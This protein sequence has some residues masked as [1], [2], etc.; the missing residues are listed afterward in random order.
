MFKFDIP[1]FESVPRLNV[2]LRSIKGEGDSRILFVSDYVPFSDYSETNDNDATLLGAEEGQVFKNVLEFVTRKK[3]DGSQYD[4]RE[5]TVFNWSNAPNNLKGLMVEK[6]FTKTQ[7]QNY[8]ERYNNARLLAF[9]RKMKPDTVIIS[10]MD[11]FKSFMLQYQ[12]DHYPVANDNFDFKNKFGRLLKFKHPDIKPFNIMGTVD[13]RR[14]ATQKQKEIKKYTNL[15][16]FLVEAFELALHGRN[17]HTIDLTDSK[18]YYVDTYKKFCAFYKRLMRAKRVSIDSEGASLARIANK[19]FSIQFALNK[20]DAYFVPLDH[21]DSPFTANELIRIKKALK[22]YF[23]Y[24]KS[25]WHIYQF[26]RHDVEQFI[27]Q[28]GVRY[29]NHRIYDCMAGEF[30]LDENRKLLQKKGGTNS[31]DKPYALQALAEK[32]GSDIY[33][34]IPFSKGDREGMENVKFTSKVIKYGCYDVLVPWQIMECQIA[35]AARVGNENFMQF[36]LGQLSDTV[37]AVAQMEHTG[38]PLDKKYLFSLKSVDSDLDKQIKE[39][40]DKMW[41]LPSVKKTNRFLINA[42]NIPQGFTEP[43]VFKPT[44]EASKQTLFFKVLKLAP[45]K[46]NQKGGGAVDKA[47]KSFYRERVP[48]VKLLD[49]YEQLTKLKS[50]YVDAFYKKLTKDPDCIDGFIR[51]NYDYTDVTTGRLSSS[52]PNLQ[53][54]VNRGI[55]AKTIKRCFIALAGWILCKNDYSAHEVRIWAILGKDKRLSE[56]FRKGLRLRQALR[57]L[58]AKCPAE[59]D[60]FRALQKKAGWKGIKEYDQKL[61]LVARIEDETVKKIASL[62]LEIEQFGD[63]HRINYNHFYGTPILKITPDQ[64]Q[65]IKAVVFGV[66]YGKCLVYSSLVP[67]SDGLLTLGELR[68]ISL[69]G[70]KERGGFLSLRTKVATHEGMATTNASFARKGKTQLVCTLDGDKIEGLKEHKIWILRD[71]ALQFVRLDKLKEGDYLPKSVGTRLFSATVPVLDLNGST[72]RMNER[73][74]TLLGLFVAE[75]CRSGSFSNADDRILNWFSTAANRLLNDPAKICVDSKT[76]CI[77]LN[78][79]SKNFLLTHTGNGLSAD[80]FVP[81]VIRQSPKKYQQAFLQG[82]WEGDGSI[83]K[84]QGFYLCEYTTISETL[85]YQV[86]AM[87]ENMGVLCSITEFE[88]WATNGTAKQVKR[89]GYKLR[90][91]SVALAEFEAQAG[92][93][94]DGKKAALLRQAVEHMKTGKFDKLGRANAIPATHIMKRIYARLDE[95]CNATTYSYDMRNRWGSITTASKTYKLGAITGSTH[96]QNRIRFDNGLVTRRSIDSLKKK[97]ASC[98]DTLRRV[99]RNDKEM[100]NLWSELDIVSGYFWTQVKSTVATGT[101]KPVADLSVP[102]P[103]SYHVNGI[104]G[105][106]TAKGLAETKGIDTE[107]NAEKLI[108]LLFEKFE[109]GGNWIKKIIA[110]AQKNFY[111]KSPVGMIRHLW[112]YLH[113]KQGVR[114]AMDRRGPNSVIQGLASQMGVA[115]IRI[116]QRLIWKLFISRGHKI[117]WKVLT[118]FVHDSLE[119]MCKL[120]LL[121]IHLYLLEHAGASQIHK[122]F[123]EKYGMKF[124]VGLELEFQMGPTMSD[125]ITWGWSSGELRDV[126][127]YTMDWQEKEL[128]VKFRRNSIMKAFETN[129]KI[130]TKLRMKELTAARLSGD[131]EMTMALKTSNVDDLGFTFDVDGGMF[132]EEDHDNVLERMAA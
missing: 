122:L 105:H 111:V 53:N 45:L 118:N 84:H 44:T 98:P 50:T 130:I 70:K 16:G 68:Q 121:P 2:T 59:A 94:K 73:L 18:F 80:K 14:C 58:M 88:T 30:A 34:R 119:S 63:I 42:A 127:N 97:I 7:A 79:A 95:L 92:F 110:F 65:S 12:R 120:H 75:G 35:E 123:T 132:K 39:T 82:L 17:R 37:L 69:K 96:H 41:E 99:I 91:N 66:I 24:G 87:L 28:L 112:A 48:E 32:Y 60:A 86:K 20:T 36:V 61:K 102:G 46:L 15:I 89:I 77:R 51:A 21:P 33:S 47:F 13:I 101:T 131:P 1:A 31:I 78:T 5:L 108:K 74:A 116:M 126:V 10:G 72:V 62:T 113:N 55:L 25:K 8:A 56:A 71:D 93:M 109:G 38:A 6:N 85:A 103:H 128:G 22:H 49:D 81:L 27:A 11:A 43:R 67:T 129:L 76:P 115:S 117:P 100:Q 19:L 64:R 83:W 57:I 106:N 9:I 104:I 40:V 54:I 107:E 29:Y 52:K 26:A 90:I 124:N 23:E 3:P 125:L 4:L 114:N